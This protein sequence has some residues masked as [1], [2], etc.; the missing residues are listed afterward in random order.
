MS[1]TPPLKAF[2][3]PVTPLAQNCTVVACPATNKAAVIDPGGEIDHLLQ[4]IT[5]RGLTIEKI[6]LTNGFVQH[7]GGAQALKEA[8]G[9]MIEGPHRDELVWVDGIEHQ[10]REFGMPEARRFTPDRWLNDGDV[11]TLGATQFEVLHTPG[12]TPGHVVFFHR[13]GRF[14]QVGGVLFKGSIGRTDIPH[15]DE[16]QLIDSITRKLW[17]LGDDVRFVA[18]HGPMSTFGDERRSN[19]FVSDDVLAGRRT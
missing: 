2:I 19:P 1:E 15:G 5:R 17:P 12:R 18:G 8:T 11:V 7:A 3:A 6:W 10:G 16:D 9:A 14:A 13:E 4:E